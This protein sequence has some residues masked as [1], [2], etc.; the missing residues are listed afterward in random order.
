M[1]ISGMGNLKSGG[2]KEKPS[3]SSGFPPLLLPETIIVSG[4]GRS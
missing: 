4:Y 3:S 2:D 1:A